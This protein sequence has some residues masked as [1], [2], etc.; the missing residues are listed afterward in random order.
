MAV[1]N[2]FIEAHRA[3]D[4]ARG[5]GNGDRRLAAVLVLLVRLTLGDA[6]DVWFV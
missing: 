1:V 3:D 6:E 2:V 5:L 4:D